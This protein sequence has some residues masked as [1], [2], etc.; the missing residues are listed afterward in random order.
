LTLSITVAGSEVGGLEIGIST[1]VVTPPETAAAVQD[2]K[3]S[4][5]EKL[6]AL[7]CT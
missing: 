3:S 1:I 7:T 2:S 5:S 4:L 6:G